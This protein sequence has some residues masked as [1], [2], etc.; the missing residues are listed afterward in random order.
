MTF[1]PFPEEEGR[2][3]GLYP[4]PRGLICTHI[5]GGTL[6]LYRMHAFSPKWAS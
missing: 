5:F 1:A 6:R 4:S 3:P 2:G